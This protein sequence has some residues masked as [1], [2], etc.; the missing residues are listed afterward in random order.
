MT[1]RCG[2]I[3]PVDVLSV[4][5]ASRECVKFGPPN[6]K[7]LRTYPT[8][9]NNEIAVTELFNQSIHRG[10]PVHFPRFLGIR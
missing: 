10:K 4:P 2:E 1:K 5:P 7:P 6:E 9:A 8:A 3:V